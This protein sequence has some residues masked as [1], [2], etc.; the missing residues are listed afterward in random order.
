[1]PA[2]AALRH[3][4]GE[5][6]RDV[7]AA[8]RRAGNGERAAGIVGDQRQVGEVGAEGEV[9][10]PGGKAAIGG[11]RHLVVAELEALGGEARLV[12][13]H[14]AGERDAAGEHVVERGLGELQVVG[15]AIEIEVETAAERG[16]GAGGDER[17]GAAE[18][19]AGKAGERRD[20]ARFDADRAIEDVVVDLAGQRR[21]ERLAD[22][23]QLG[24][25][26]RLTGIPQAREAEAGAVAQR[27]GDVGV[28]AGDAGDIAIGIEGHPPLGRVGEIGGNAACRDGQLACGEIA[29]G[30]ALRIDVGGPVV[31]AGAAEIDMQVGPLDA[32]RAARHRQHHGGAGRIGDDA[33]DGEQAEEA[34]AGGR[35]L[36]IEREL[37]AAQGEVGNLDAAFALAP[38]LRPSGASRRRRTADRSARSGCRSD[39]RDRH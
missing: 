19:A 33:V 34:I 4:A 12:A 21:G 25:L 20:R 32:G 15:G 14:A 39:R 10:R 38:V 24:D 1:M 6:E 22:Q 3:F 5:G 36:A 30:E 18:V 9:G 13:C 7:A 8:A 27:G 2:R 29:V 31:A 37:A 26:H 16:Q 28:R 35:Q 23:P 17:H 11:D